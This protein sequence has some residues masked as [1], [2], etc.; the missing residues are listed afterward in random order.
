MH[1]L[2]RRSRKSMSLKAAE[3]AAAVPQVVA[4]RLT[5]LAMA[6]P[7]LSVRDRKEFQRMVAEK[8][9]AFG[10]AWSAMG[11]Q[12]LHAQQAMAVSLWQSMWLPALGGKAPTAL[13]TQMHRAALAIAGKG[14]GPVHRKAMAN[15]KRLARTKLR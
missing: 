5:R 6:G 3:L 1:P 13:A 2:K 10:E 12:T 9:A 11:R 8:N 4:H 15:A 14:L 7:T